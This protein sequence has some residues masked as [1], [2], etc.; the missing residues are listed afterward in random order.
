MVFDLGGWVLRVSENMGSRGSQVVEL[1]L[2][3]DM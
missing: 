2:L 3:C 1:C